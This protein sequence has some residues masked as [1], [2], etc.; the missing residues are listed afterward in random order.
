MQ[1]KPLQLGQ[2]FLAAEVA[3]YASKP[4]HLY[5]TMGG[6]T[7]VAQQY[8][9]ALVFSASSVDCLMPLEIELA[10]KLIAHFLP[11]FVFSASCALDSVYWVDAAGGTA[12]VRMAAHT[13]FVAAAL[14]GVKLGWRSPPR[15]AEALPWRDAA[16]ARMEAVGA[17]AVGPGA[18]ILPNVLSAAVED[19]RT[20]AGPDGAA[21]LDAFQK[22]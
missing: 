3:G 11:G 6:N 22:R 8:L 20:K 5:P 12:P 17:E 1:L 4:V 2:P 14:S 15:E 13:L 21:I 18:W 19:W 10:D 16:L 9:Q 7:T